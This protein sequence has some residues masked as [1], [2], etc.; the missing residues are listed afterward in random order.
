MQPKGTTSTERLLFKYC[1]SSFL[2]LWSYANVFRD[3]RQNGVGDGKELC[4]VLVVFG[5]N[6]IIFSDKTC[7]FPQKGDPAVNW[8]RW[9][10]RAI[11]ASKSQLAGAE[12]WIR[13]FPERVFADRACTTPLHVKLPPSDRAR[14][15]KIAVVS[16]ATQAARAFFGRGSGN[17]MSV[18]VGGPPL[19]FAVPLTE[20]DGSTIH[21]LD[22][23]TLPVL[24]RELDTI[25]DFVTYLEAKERLI[26][27]GRLIAVAGEEELLGLFLGMDAGL[28]ESID[29]MTLGSGEFCVAE[30]VY[31][32]I[33]RR[34]EYRKYVEAN[35]SSYA[36]DLLI[37]KHTECVLSGTLV[38]GSEQ[39]IQ[40][41]ESI[42]R[43]LASER[44]VHRRVLID[45]FLELIAKASKD[46]VT[47]RTVSISTK[48]ETIYVFQVY[49]RIVPTEAEY[50]SDRQTALMEYCI[51]TAW[52][53]RESRCVI[54][55]SCDGRGF[56]HDS[57]D[58]FMLQHGDWTPELEELAR[59]IHD[60]HATD[61][62]E[63]MTVREA[64]ISHYR[65]WSAGGGPSGKQS[66][67]QA[68]AKGNRRRFK[69]RKK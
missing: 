44:R 42:L 36:W 14:Y 28:R 22:E 21:V 3:Q 32:D 37:S 33:L 13:L 56:V 34:T 63:P 65:P 11:Q 2:Q 48:P 60:E 57:H 39:S 62:I 41:N 23:V 15:F 40:R 7:E 54:G 38:A 26:Q 17:L 47:S 45:A 64:P 31:D 53:R 20:A 49:P 58:V 69:R 25:G 55:I 6:V 68:S 1:R 35:K 4:D 61:V 9:E 27:T 18:R 66:G 51:I 67:T 29:V 19:P 5:D 59:E 12:R 52:R 24:M 10:R 16:G 43:A 50:R 30:G 8:K 46:C